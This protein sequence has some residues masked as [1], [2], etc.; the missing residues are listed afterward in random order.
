M[1]RRVM[2]AMRTT[3]KVKIAKERLKMGI[4]Y[5]HWIQQNWVIEKPYAHLKISILF[6]DLKSTKDPRDDFKSLQNKQ[7]LEV[8][9]AGCR[10]NEAMVIDDVSYSYDMYQRII[11]QVKVVVLDEGEW[12]YALNIITTAKPL[13]DIKKGYRLS[14]YGSFFPLFDILNDKDYTLIEMLCY[15]QQQSK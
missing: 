11:Y 2:A 10:F 15:K 12:N 3:E 4:T 5:L 8:L 6:D 14:L 13:R 1:P 9:D 7:K